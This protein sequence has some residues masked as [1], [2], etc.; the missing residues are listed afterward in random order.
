MNIG[1]IVMAIN[2]T[3]QKHMT[4]E[5]DSLLINFWLENQWNRMYSNCKLTHFPMSLSLQMPLS[6]HNQQFIISKYINSLFD[7]I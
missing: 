3:K 1:M 7:F 5:Y 4:S 6:N 2:Q